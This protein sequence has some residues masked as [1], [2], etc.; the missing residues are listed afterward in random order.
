MSSTASLPATYGG[1]TF[2]HRSLGHAADVAAGR[3]WRAVGVQDEF[4]P[5]QE[6]LLA[7]PP[8]TLGQVTDPDAALMLGRPDLNQMRRQLDALATAYAARGIAVHLHDER[9]A[10]PIARA[11]GHGRLSLN[12]SAP[13]RCRRGRAKRPRPTRRP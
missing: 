12:S 11:C 1:A 10:P 9:T 8:D 3:H 2:T 13:F 5:V 6:V 4:S 7:V